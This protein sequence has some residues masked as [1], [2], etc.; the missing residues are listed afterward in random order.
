MG[1]EAAPQQVAVPYLWDR[2]PSFKMAPH[3]VRVGAGYLQH[4]AVERMEWPDLNPTG[5]SLD[6]LQ[7]DQHDHTG[8]P[9]TDP[10]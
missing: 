7:S 1:L 6:V 8:G 10:G 2:T 4:V 3:R 5:I 9:V